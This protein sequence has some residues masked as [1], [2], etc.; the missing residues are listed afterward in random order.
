MSTTTTQTIAFLGATGGCT[1]PVLARALTAGHHCTALARTPAKLRTA[2][3]STAGV[4]ADV[5]DRNLTI[6]AGSASD[7]GAMRSLLTSVPGRG[8]EEKTLVDFIISGIGGAPKLQWSLRTPAT[9]DN[10]HI[11]ESAAQGVEEALRGLLAEGYRV[12]SSGAAEQEKKPVMITISTTG[13]SRLQRDVPLL[14]LPLYHWL[15]KIPHDDKRA[16]EDRVVAATREG[17]LRDFVIV[18]PSLLVDGEAKGRQALRVGWEPAT[19]KS[20]R[21]PGPAV[22]YTTTRDDV[23]AW[24]WEE[25]VLNTEKWRGKCVSLTY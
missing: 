23:A 8:A 4:A 1:L 9:I 12:R 20:E 19:E 7:A 13:I 18:R 25:A 3:I 6:V 21:A 16:M 10:P 11:C 22:G 15:G 14:F 5:V 2:L 24:I 17:T